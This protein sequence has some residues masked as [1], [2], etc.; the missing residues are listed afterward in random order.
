VDSLP[1]LEADRYSFIF[2]P[3]SE[4]R[5]RV[6]VYQKPGQPP[7]SFAY[8]QSLKLPLRI[9]QIRNAGNPGSFDAQSYFAHRS[10]YWSA[11]VSGQ[12]PVERLPGFCGTTTQAA[13][14]TLR[15]A[16]L[17]RIEY[18]ASGDAYL[19]AMLGALL[20]GDNARME[21]AWTDGYRRTGTYHAIVI[22]GLHITILAFALHRV[23]TLLGMRALPAHILCAAMAVL[24]ALIC[25]LSAPVVRAAGGYILFLGARLLYRRGRVL[26]LLAAVAIAYLLFDPRQL[27]EASF[28]LSFLAVLTLGAL[29]AP[30]QELTSSPWERAAYELENRNFDR[31]V[32]IVSARRVEL[33]LMVRTL[34]LAL[35]SLATSAH[36]W[37]S[38]ITFVSTAAFNLLLTSAVVLVGLSLPTVLFFHRLTFASL[39]ANLPVVLL[40]T[41]AV[42]LG[43]MALIVGPLAKPLLAALLGASRAVVDWHLTWD[44]TLRIPDPP[45]WLV[46]TLPISLLGAAIFARR[47]PRYAAWGMLPCL[48]LF[49][50]LAWHPDSRTPDLHHGKLEVTA[51]DVG[52]GDSLFLAS[53]GGH[54]ALLDG[55]GTRSTRYDPG[56][57]IVSP[58]LWTRRIASLNILIASHA[59]Q[60]HMGGLLAAL[61]NFRP[62]ELWVS[63]HVKG[64]LWESLK[65]LAHRHHVAIRYLAAGDRVALGEMPVEVLWPPQD[66]V[67]ERS[68]LA[69]LVLL[70]RHG[71]KRFLFTGDVDSSVE[72]RLLAAGLAHVDVI[73][74]AHHGSRYSSSTEFLDTT[75][76]AL[77]ISSSGF[78]NSFSHPHPLVQERLR[79]AHVPLFRTDTMGQVTVLSDG[80][81][82]RVDPYRG[83]PSPAIRW[84]SSWASIE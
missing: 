73:K 45:Q 78:A 29:A 49:G 55:G 31:Q 34:S 13:I 50:Y 81:H 62:Q 82:L 27:F 75:R 16:L 33:L 11:T 44:N 21:D 15:A 35:P 68:N 40:L 4:A 5:M 9:R 8:G 70:M 41:L 25:D 52:Q 6:S 10:I 61:E 83:R 22:S 37:I 12:H 26:N 60:D 36:R 71:E 28:Q 20:L 46:L 24:Y 39:T 51:I 23:L 43:F 69:S 74:L 67:I 56:E 7:P 19:Q 17:R 30:L 57:S 77:A 32:P 14:Y 48:F 84:F 79:N 58:Y 66:E 18:L 65:Q 47:V 1:Q 72:A 38:R 64:D 54:T 63:S 42:P 2:A 80:K 3:V 59:D 76:P 53:P